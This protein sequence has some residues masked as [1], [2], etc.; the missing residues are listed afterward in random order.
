MPLEAPLP[1]CVHTPHCPGLW[2]GHE[3]P[4]PALLGRQQ[5]PGGLERSCKGL[6]ARRG[7]VGPSP[8]LSFLLCDVG[9]DRRCRGQDRTA[10]G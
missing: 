6:A 10:R 4:T 9:G 3:A 5:M 8:G 1:G 7:R 2:R